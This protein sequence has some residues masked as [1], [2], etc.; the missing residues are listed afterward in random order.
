MRV[1]KSVNS[2]E[3]LDPS[4][5]TRFFSG[6]KDILGNGS[7]SMEGMPSSRPDAEPSATNAPGP[8]APASSGAI[9]RFMYV[10]G[11]FFRAISSPDRP[12][13]LLIDD[14]H[15]G[16]PGSINVLATGVINETYPGFLVIGTVEAE[17]VS[18]DSH[19]ASKLR[20]I[21]DQGNELVHL[22]INNLDETELVQCLE[23]F[24][25]WTDPDDARALSSLLHR[26]TLGDAFFMTELLCWF[27]EEKALSLDFASQFWS[28]DSQRVHDLLASCP[29]LDLLLSEKISTLP[30]ETVQLL[31][32]ASCLGQVIDDA[33]IEDALGLAIQDA[34]EHALSRGG[35]ITYDTIG[36]RKRYRFLNEHIRRVANQLIPEGDRLKFHLE[37]GRRLWRRLDELSM[38]ERVFQVLNLL[39]VGQDLIQKQKERRAVASMCLHA[40]AMAARSSAF[41]VARDY[42]AMGITLLG[43]HRWRDDYELALALHNASAEMGI[44]SGNL[45]DMETHI[46]SVMANARQFPDTMHARMAKLYSYGM[47]AGRYYEAFREGVKLLRKLGVKLPS[48]YSRARLMWELLSVRRLV[49]GKSDQFFMRM[50]ALVDSQKR[51]CLQILTLMCQYV[52]FS[53]PDSLPFV[54]LQMMKITILSGTS[55]FAST[56]IVSY[57]MLCI[58]AYGDVEMG[59]RFG[60]LGLAVLDRNGPSEFLPRVHGTFY[61]NIFV[62]KRPLA[63]ALQPIAKA[64]RIGVHTGDLQGAFLCAN[65][66][67]IQ[68]LEAGVRLSEVEP[69][70]DSIQQRL[71][72]TSQ[73]SMSR[74]FLPLSRIVN[75]FI[76]RPTD[77][78]DWDEL[79]LAAEESGVH[80]DTISVIYCQL[81]LAWVHD[82]FNHVETMMYCI[83]HFSTVPPGASRVGLLGLIGAYAMGLARKERR[84][85]PNVTIA[86]KMI[87]Q[88]RFYAS[89]EPSN[90]QPRLHLVQAELASYQGNS[91]RA[92]QKY[93]TAVALSAATHCLLICAKANECFARHLHR[94]SD[95]DAERNQD[96]LHYFSEACRLYKDWGGMVKY[97]SLSSEIEALFPCC[98]W[99][100]SAR[101]NKRPSLLL[102]ESGAP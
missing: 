30:D 56:A 83:R 74:S 9:L 34:L 23:G 102:H 71:K 46:K 1:R 49:S 10:F 29:S 36:N 78:A 86:R 70:L 5:L 6:L 27:Y 88:L 4:L 93:M 55:E 92:Q 41:L 69:E 13:V 43:S 37:L 31:Q 58:A 75:D 33:L 77:V 42:L 82:D 47:Q 76:G 32:V 95:D 19:L 101:A 60:R 89:F 8:P 51:F 14:L 57:G 100:P 61:G 20:E 68:S 12:L 62:Y 81:A 66:F 39:R 80:L 11:S 25:H 67:C 16:D 90:A 94:T 22:S 15:F 17:I 85:N 40:G 45:D 99:K 54:V 97:R 79:R 48:K 63:E 44:C 96:S 50:P 52:L 21:E 3:G 35:L 18:P 7:G 84:K 98:S 72:A 38:E 28:W 2:V 73:Q 26:H 64:Y 53:M 91:A 59:Y 24:F 87:K 65:I